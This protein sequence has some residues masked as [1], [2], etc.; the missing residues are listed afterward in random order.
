MAT[1]AQIEQAL[2]AADAA[3][4]TEDAQRL[5]AEY[6]RVRDAQS[7]AAASPAAPPANPQAPEHAA[8]PAPQRTLA[9]EAGRSLGLGARSLIGGAADLVGIVADPFIH[10][11]NMLGGQ[12]ATMRQGAE[13]LSDK[14]GLPTP[15][16]GTERVASGIT[17][18]L[19]GGGGFI[20][21]GKALAGKA[22]GLVRAVGEGLS[23]RPTAQLASAT[24]G[25]VAAD[26]MR[27]AGYGGGAQ[28]L[29]GV[30][31]GIAPGGVSK[32]ASTGRKIAAGASP[33]NIDQRVGEII[34][35]EADSPNSLLLGQPSRV[36]GVQRPL[37]EESLDA[38]V[39]RLERN[40]R[41]TQ[42]G[43]DALDRANNAARVR[44]IEAFAGDDTAIAAAKAARDKASTGLRREALKIEGVDTN[45]LLSQI[46]RAET[47]LT[48]RPAVQ[49]GL[50]QVRELLTREVPDAERLKAARAPLEAFATTGR[51]SAADYEAAREALRAIRR[52]EVPAVT[53]QSKTGQDALR[54]AQKALARTSVGVDK[55]AV[56]DNVR[57][58]IGDM[59]GGKFGGDS[60]A[61]LAGSRE[62][63]SVKNQ[64]DRVLA[65]QAPEYGQY[66][67][68]FREGSK[69]INRM[70]VGQHL[71]TPKSGSAILDPVTGKQVLTPAQF[72]RQARDL[73]SVA[74]QAT[75]F[76]KAKADRVLEPQDFEAVR[77][78]QD[79]LERRAF[80]GTA[81]SGGNSQTFERGF[82]DKRIDSFLKSVPVAGKYFEAMG[83]TSQNLIKRRL[84]EVLQNPEQARAILATLSKKERDFAE[85]LISR[86]LGTGSSIPSAEN[87]PRR[88]EPPTP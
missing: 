12:Q 58:T 19:A 68:A 32:L 9:E 20:G 63:M 60:A 40:A 50:R 35:K 44:A 4:N 81:G 86:S 70:E 21:A 23:A 28:L 59:L 69:P 82:I 11:V 41:S 57:K 10:G 53:F 31:G 77:A 61:A 13:R 56:L 18:A 6:V 17:N 5:A 15:E 30:V 42:P 34:R 87:S 26:A 73:D 83:E 76:R 16:T 27:E 62:L 37:A 51:K 79:D 67:D 75:G 14:L 80:A 85:Y 78:V 66:L 25:T 84:S 65:K 54:E 43:W 22:P 29:A 1:L 48:G 46:K 24:G 7:G 72:S 88:I 47:M 45:R 3:G 74:Q 55:V 71:L 38:G 39:A 64:L 49:S 36:P 33:Q 52:G 2:R 8:P